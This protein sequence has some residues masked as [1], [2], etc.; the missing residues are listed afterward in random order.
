V[1]KTWK[2]EKKIL[3]KKSWSIF[4]FQSNYFRVLGNAGWNFFVNFVNKWCRVM[5]YE[6][7]KFNKNRI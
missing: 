4:R 2:R 5:W 3:E 6:R 1:I 7:I